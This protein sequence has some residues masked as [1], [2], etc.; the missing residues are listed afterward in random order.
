[1]YTKVY[2][3]FAICLIFWTSWRM[4]RKNSKSRGLN[5]FVKIDTHLGDS[6]L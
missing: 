1:M 2:N 6:C 3:N 4:H 5:D